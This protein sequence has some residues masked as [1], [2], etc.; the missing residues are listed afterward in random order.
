MTTPETRYAKGGNV[1]I[2]YQVLGNGSLPLVLVPGFISHVEQVWEEPRVAYLL[3]R[4]A[5]FCRLIWFDKRGTG[6]SDRVAAMPTIEERMDDVRIVM[7]AV[8][9]QRAALLG[10]S[11]GGPMTALFAATYPHRTSALVLYGT[12]ARVAWAPDYP[13]GRRPERHEAILD[14]IENAWGTAT[15]V[16]IYTPSLAADEPYRRW[17]AAFERTSASPGAALALVQMNWAIDVRPVLPTIRIPTLVLH[18][19]EDRAISVEHGDTLPRKS[20]ARNTW[21]SPALTTC[22]GRAIQ[23][24]SLTKWRS[25]SPAPATGQNRIECSRRCYSRTSSARLKGRQRWVIVDGVV[26]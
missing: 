20:L 25:S 22:R 5:S 19:A 21:R 15:S 24:A 8:G 17:A 6:L 7:D 9:T 4:L 18:R 3:N 2:A 10:I 13:W 11:E 14:S 23:T 26:S 16:S 12:Y 1:H